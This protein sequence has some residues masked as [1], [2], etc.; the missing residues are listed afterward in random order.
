M[1]AREP[2]STAR[3][4][5]WGHFWATTLAGLA[6]SILLTTRASEWAGEITRSAGIGAT[7]PFL[8]AVGLIEGTI[9]GGAQWMALSRF[10]ARDQRGVWLRASALGMGTAWAL[11]LA[12]GAAAPRTLEPGGPVAWI[13]AL[14]SGGV[15]GALIAGLEWWALGRW[16]TGGRAFVMRAA[17]GW[18]VTLLPVLIAAP[19]LLAGRMR[20]SDV[21]GVV[22]FGCLSAAVGSGV[23]A[24]ALEGAVRRRKDL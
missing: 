17:G 7:I 21:V 5:T 14:A 11:A 6:A 22:V 20:P 18:C 16:F 9:V 1:A 10:V 13:A 4:R 24:W 15:L 2:T 8:I 23:V 3:L 12:L 19:S